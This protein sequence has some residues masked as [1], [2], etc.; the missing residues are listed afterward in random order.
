MIN[1]NVEN[2]HFKKDK[3][4]RTWLE[5]FKEK[6]WQTENEVVF[7]KKWF[8]KKLSM[9]C[10]LILFWIIIILLKETEMSYVFLDLISWLS[11]PIY[12]F[13][14]NFAIFVI[15]TF[16]LIYWIVTSFKIIIYDNKWN[17]RLI[18][19]IDQMF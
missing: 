16:S 3:S 4:F 9:S 13:I 17:K 10:L 5:N 7:D 11:L 15:W 14:V 6:K 18:N 1:N 2:I 8:I 12:I 19:K